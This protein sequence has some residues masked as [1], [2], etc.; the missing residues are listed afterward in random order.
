MQVISVVLFLLLAPLAG[1]LLDGL[2][3]I[4]AARMQG[5]KGPPF[6]QPFCD[7]PNFFPNR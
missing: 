6:L 1:C 4:I 7:L 2:D 5:R 3:R